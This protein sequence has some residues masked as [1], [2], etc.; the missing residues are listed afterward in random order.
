MKRD[1]IN[2]FAD[3]RKTI[4]FSGV[5]HL[6]LLML[7]MLLN[8]GLD[9]SPP[10]YAEISF[11]S[12]QVR[13]E[14]PAPARKTTPA[15]Q[16]TP[17]PPEPEPV[18]AEQSA[19]E[20]PEVTQQQSASPQAPPVNLPER[21]M[22]EDEEPQIIQR[23]SDKLTRDT[24]SEDLPMRADV[25]QSEKSGEVA[26]ER[27]G[28]EKISANPQRMALDDQGV[29]PATEIGGPPNNQPFQISGEAAERS[30]LN[31]V[32]PEYP[33][34]LQKEAVIKI[35]FTVTPDGRVGQMIPVKKDSPKLEE[36]TLNALENWR[37]NPLPPSA[38][39]QPVEGVITFR[40][41]L[42]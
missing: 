9:I 14:T 12:S 13:S 5:V 37:F 31:K 42:E 18:E 35:R 33:E 34:D 7:L 26:P 19:P 6:I 24:G 1:I 16:V 22:L 39:Q 41:E 28:D 2:I 32:V 29:M 3:I 10:D 20:Q 23:N 27:A 4:V 21:R 38:E 30:I 36:I 17:E 15:E 8:V 11:V 25:Y 40:Y